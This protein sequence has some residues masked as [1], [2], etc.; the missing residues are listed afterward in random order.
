[1]PNLFNPKKFDVFSFTKKIKGLKDKF[2]PSETCLVL[3]DD[4]VGCFITDPSASI[5]HIKIGTVE[6]EVYGSMRLSEF[7][8]R[9]VTYKMVERVCTIEKHRLKGIMKLLYSHCLELGF[10]LMSDSTHT[11]FGSKD[12]WMKSAVYFPNKSIYLVN[13]NTN[14]KTTYSTQPEHK[15]W[16]RE[17]NYDF[18]ILEKEDKIYLLEQLQKS[19]TLSQ[20]QFKFFI[21]HIDSL[22]DKSN[23]RLTLE[24]KTTTNI[25]K[26]PP[27]VA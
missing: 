17:P 27:P 7:I 19:N 1:M 25:K 6:N 23:V 4:K 10:N 18:D 16:G 5:M 14:Y 20:E 21:T 2:H 24:D 22:E 15:I 9:G 11:T 3:P 13:L 26:Y 12:F 8:F